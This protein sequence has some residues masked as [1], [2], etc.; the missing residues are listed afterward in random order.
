M[1]KISRSRFEVD[2]KLAAD[3]KMLLEVTRIAIDDDWDSQPDTIEVREG[4]GF[5][6]LMEALR[7]HLEPA[8]RAIPVGKIE[9]LWAG[10]KYFTVK[11]A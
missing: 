7:K 9:S 6:V 3:G 4:D 8:Y 1:K 2:V 11:E 5:E 10:F